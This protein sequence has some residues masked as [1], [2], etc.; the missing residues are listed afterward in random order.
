MNIVLV[1]GIIFTLWEGVIT[2]LF[3]SRSREYYQKASENWSTGI[4]PALIGLMDMVSLIGLFVV[5]VSSFFVMSALHAVIFCVGMF[6]IVIIGGAFG[7]KKADQK[8]LR[9]THQD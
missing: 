1:L 4:A 9:Q 5:G 3:P 2:H 7:G 8:A 6:I